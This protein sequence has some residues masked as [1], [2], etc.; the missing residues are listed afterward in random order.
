MHFVYLLPGNPVVH[1]GY[2]EPGSKDIR[3]E[4]K[5]GEIIEQSRASEINETEP[6]NDALRWARNPR[7]VIANLQFSPGSA[8]SPVINLEGEVIGVMIGAVGG[9]KNRAVLAPVEA[10]RALVAQA[11]RKGLY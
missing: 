7:F 10:V 5:G 2:A 1:I 11:A 6:E 3:W 9:D 4:F 8:G